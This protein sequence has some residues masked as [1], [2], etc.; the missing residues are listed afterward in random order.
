VPSDQS[1]CIKESQ[2]SDTGDEQPRH[3]EH[4]SSYTRRNGPPFAPSKQRSR[5]TNKAQGDDDDVEERVHRWYLHPKGVRVKVTVNECYGDFSP[6]DVC[7]LRNELRMTRIMNKIAA[8]L[9]LTLTGMAADISG[10]WNGT[11]SVPGSDHKEPQYF[12]LKQDRKKLTGSGGPDAVEQYPILNGTV[13]NDVV[14]FELT[15]GEWTFSYDLRTVKQEMSGDLHLRSKEG[16]TRT[17]HVTLRKAQLAAGSGTVQPKPQNAIRGIVDAFDRFPIVAI[18]EGHSLREVGDFYVSLVK[19]NGFQEKVNDIVIEFGSRLHQPTLDRY[20]NGEEVPLTELQ[21]VWRNTTKVFAFESPVYAELLKAVR[22]ANRKL[23]RV[24]R[25]RVLAGDSP[26]DWTKVT[27]HQQWESYQPNDLSFAEVINGQVLA[28]SRKA[29]VVMGGSHVSKSADPTRD[30]NTT[31]LVE[32]K[33]PGT[34]YVA[35]LDQ[36]KKESAAE[37]KPPALVATVRP[38]VSDYSDALLFL[39]ENLSWAQPNWQQYRADPVYLKELDRRG[40]RNLHYFG[41]A[42][43]PIVINP[44]ITILAQNALMLLMLSGI[45]LVANVLLASLLKW[46]LAQ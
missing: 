42:G 8:V 46:R 44:V 5:H 27:T 9:L 26:I 32:R 11:F 43:K 28:H 1:S 13:E 6:T 22:D 34:V 17:A 12:I 20:V 33:H 19:D 4:H 37:W 21:Q 10:T 39:G 41:L 40:L 23:P 18:G 14:T 31:I 3:E 30:P 7:D 15:T 25:I 16:D 36:S 2:D 29:L 45:L 24:H 38:Y 35:L